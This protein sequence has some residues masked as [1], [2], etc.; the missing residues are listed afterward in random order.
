MTDSF[1]LLLHR[2]VN[3][4]AP[5]GGHVKWAASRRDHDNFPIAIRVTAATKLALECA[6]AVAGGGRIR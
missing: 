4:Q 6:A 5:L 2:F 1:E 3:A